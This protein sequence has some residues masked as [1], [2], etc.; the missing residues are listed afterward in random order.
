MIKSYNSKA[1]HESLMKLKPY[2]CEL[3]GNTGIHNNL[4][5]KLQVDH[6]DGNNSNND[7]TNL[8]FLCPNC[9]SQTDTYVGKN[10][11]YNKVSKP[12][13]EEFIELYKKYSIKE[14]SL[15]KAVTTRVVYQWFK[16]YIKD[17]KETPIITRKLN[18]DNITSIRNSS[19]N[20]KDLASEFDVSR[21]LINQ[22][23]K[24]EIYKYC[25]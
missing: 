3:C 20:D 15:I 4:P 2:T 7:I 19:K 17:H 23:R 18:C 22:I 1:L 8:R 16:F 6:I 14:I 13:K 12:T 24:N 25:N 9:H 11:K 21:R 5:L 10:A